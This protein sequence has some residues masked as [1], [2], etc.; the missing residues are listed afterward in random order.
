MASFVKRGS[1][2]QY[3]VSRRINGKP[4]PIRKGGFRTKKEAQ[5]AAAV[6]E[7]RLNKGLEIHTTPV[8]LNEYFDNWI[9]LYKCHLEKN[10]F[11]NYLNTKRVVNEH[12]A[13]SILQ[14]M[15]KDDYQAFLNEYG[16]DKA[17]STVNRVHSHIK[18]CVQEA[19]EE[20]IV[21]RDFTSR[22]VIPG[23]ESKRS[24]DKHLHYNESNKLLKYLYANAD[25]DSI[26]LLLLL[27][28]VSG[29]RFAELIALKREDFNFKNNTITINKT[30]GYL[31]STGK[32]K[33]STKTDTSNRVIKINNR[34]MAV[35]K[36][37][38]KETP[39]NIHRLIFFSPQS[40]YKVF[41]NT[42]V[43]K[44]LKKILKSLKISQITIHGLRHTHVSILL[45]KGISLH[46]I[47]ERLGHKDIDTTLK[48]YAHMIK[49]LREKDEHKTMEVLEKMG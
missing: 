33:R 45:Y 16:K 30:Q 42:A 23:R 35:F 25:G 24:E 11:G 48:E 44:R 38:F 31:P 40:K 9:N 8:Y 34:T 26:N 19:I 29:M 1:T 18:A 47:A 37:H 7:D 36:K 32:G 4:K 12:L 13:D 14:N 27:A 49:E 5:V 3:T 10:T 22:V 46:Y 41:S 2:W 17:K 43:N 15:R 20:G 21:H 6:V 28:L 39:E